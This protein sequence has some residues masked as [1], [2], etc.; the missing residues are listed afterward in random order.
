MIKWSSSPR[1][2]REPATP[3]VDDG[4]P[5]DDRAIARLDKVRGMLTSMRRTEQIRLFDLIDRGQLQ[6]DEMRP[7]IARILIESLNGPRSEHARRLWTGWFDP[8]LQRDDVM[9]LLA[10]RLPGSLHVV[11]AGAWW[12]TLSG[13]M[14][15]L[16]RRIQTA[17]TEQSRSQP[18]ERIMTSPE[19]QVWAEQL[20]QQTLTVLAEH[21]NN[22]ATTHRLATNANAHRMRLIKSRGLTG[23]AA[24]LTSADLT[25]LEVMMTAA[26]GWKRLGTSAI[27]ADPERLL[28]FA[29]TLG[30]ANCPP[31]GAALLP[32]ARLH[33]SRD[34]DFALDVY[35]T[36]DLPLVQEAIVAHFQFAAQMV[37]HWV[38]GRFLD[39]PVPLLPA[40]RNQDAD[41][42]LRR[43]FGWYDTLHGLE[44]NRNPRVQ[45]TIDAILGPF[46]TL[47]EQELIPTLSRTIL[48][49]TPRSCARLAQDGVEFVSACRDNCAVR[50]IAM[51]DKPWLP[52]LGNHVEKLFVGLGSNRNGRPGGQPGPGLAIHAQFAELADRVGAPVP[53]STLNSGLIAVVDGALRERETFEPPER[54]LIER[55]VARCQA[56]RQSSKWWVSS[57]I[58]NLLEIASQRGIGCD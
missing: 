10:P 14:A 8:I 34:Q 39:K 4:V 1:P 52:S 27:A 58:D 41:L 19:A 38:E 23:T 12:L 40:L 9:L 57:E 35:R 51:R 45:A 55:V 29:A 30:T 50:D 36:F 43:L 15:P 6:D 5:E 46:I 56:E 28:G 24:G 21:R 26:P 47:I 31:E 3:S 20:R 37:R 13:F 42:L 25:A 7:H 33:S 54:T 22:P 49:L 18:L 32:L 11:D 16:V 2:G 48:A 17:I 44:L 53:I